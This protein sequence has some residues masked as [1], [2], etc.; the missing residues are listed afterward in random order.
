MIAFL[1]GKLLEKTPQHAVI[2]VGG[3][4]YRVFVTLNGYESLPL[5]GGDVKLH[6]VTISREDALHLYGF[7]EAEEKE[8]FLKLITV[9]RIGPKLACSILSGV[10]VDRLRSAI[11]SRDKESF[12]KI[13][14]VGPKTAERIIM[15]LKDKI[16]PEIGKVVE[17]DSDKNVSDATA[18]LV[19][20]GYQK[21]KAQA[22]VMKV[23]S[24]NPDIELGD[25]IRKSLKSLSSHV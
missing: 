4:G 14:G 15:E 2:D 3:V 23:K 1:H 20:L 13:P 17:T 12:S 24:E 6:T 5:P 16:G 8:M 19:N 22:V 21:T 10:T 11:A 18:A 7:G 25:L 9:S